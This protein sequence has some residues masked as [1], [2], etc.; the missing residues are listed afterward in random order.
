MTW[1]SSVSFL[2]Y[3]AFSGFAH[4]DRPVGDL[5]E[6]ARVRGA[7][8][9]EVV[10]PI[11]EDELLEQRPAE[12]EIH[13]G[14]LQDRNLPGKILGHQRGAPP[15]LHEIEE[16]RAAFDDIFEIPRGQ[17]TIDHHGDPGRP[18]LLCSIWKL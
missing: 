8:V 17:A 6:P 13:P 7:E 14:V 15:E 3:P 12:I 2:M 11:L 9:P 4:I 10:E 5:N 16:L 1:N 18:G